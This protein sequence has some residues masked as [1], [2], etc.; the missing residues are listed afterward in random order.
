MNLISSCLKPSCFSS[1]LPTVSAN[2]STF[3]TFKRTTEGNLTERFPRMIS[4]HDSSSR[5][6][7]DFHKKATGTWPRLIY[8]YIL[9]FSLLI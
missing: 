2:C 9:E 7:A 1:N 4:E 6:L 5:K 8:F 3:R